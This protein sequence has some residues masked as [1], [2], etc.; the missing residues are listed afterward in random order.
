MLY[1]NIHINIYFNA[2]KEY[3]LASISCMLLMI[4]LKACGYIIYVY[5][6]IRSGIGSDHDPQQLM[7]AATMSTRRLPKQARPQALATYVV[8]N[9]Q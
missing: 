4:G 6:D 2:S 9:V 3:I 7:P 1:I 8:C 5:L